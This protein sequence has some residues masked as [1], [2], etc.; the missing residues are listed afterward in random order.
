MA[1]NPD[2]KDLFKTFNDYRVE[3][4]V[5]GAHAVMYYSR[6][7]FTKDLDVWINPSPNNAQR[8]WEALRQFGAPLQDVT[9]ESF[10]DPQLVYQIGAEPNRID[11]MM[12][13]PG[14]DFATAWRG[15]VHSSYGGVPIAIIGRLDLIRAKR[16]AGRP[17]DH[18][19]A[20]ELEKGK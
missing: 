11:I 10:T 15:R 14:V 2:F 12:G 19:D 6:P 5:I 7:R 20:D 9:P 18:L 17:Q 16:A 1:V 3:Y 8:A 4:L 13:I